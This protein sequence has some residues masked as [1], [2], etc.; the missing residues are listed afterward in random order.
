MSKADASELG[1]VRRAVVISWA[2]G[3]RARDEIDHVAMGHR[4][5]VVTTVEFR[6]DG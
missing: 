1:Q 4:G 3:H 5:M 2:G 6:N